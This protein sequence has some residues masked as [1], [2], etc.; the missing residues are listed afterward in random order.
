VSTH[1]TIAELAERIGGRVRGDASGQIVGIGAIQTAQP[2]EVTWL[3]SEKYASALPSCRAGAILVPESFGPTPMSAILCRHMDA[4][5]AAVLELFAPPPARP[6]RGVHVSAIVDPTA[7]IGMDVA[8]GP[9]VVVGARASIGD[10][11]VV[12]AG[13]SVGDDVRIGADC[14]LWPGVVVRERCVL[15][16]RVIVHPN[17]VI[18]ADGFGY[19]QRDGRHC[20]ITHGGHVE[21]GDDV[22]IGAGT[23]IDRAKFGATIIGAG[24]KIDNLVQIAHNVEIGAHCL[25]IAQVGIAGSA[26]LGQYVVLGGHVGLRDHISLGDG[27]MVAACSCVSRDLPA[28]TV[29]SGIPA[30]EN[31]RYLREQASVRRL[32]E[33]AAQVRD[34]LKRVEKLEA[35]GAGD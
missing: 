14:V 11:T 3:T 13:I 19:Y 18:G 20:K 28:G 32:P 31:R 9:H 5:V 26:R 17:A 34:L 21:V 6:P 16:A 27:S 25:V 8:I 12:H 29:V 23:C 35:E 22:E 33:L 15:G 30:I 2:D 10:R 7:R 1:Y 4:A 24:T